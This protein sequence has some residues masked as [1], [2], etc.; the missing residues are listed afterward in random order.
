MQSEEKVA[1]PSNGSPIVTF[2]DCPDREEHFKWDIN[3]RD[4]GRYGGWDDTQE[5]LC[6]DA[7]H[8]SARILDYSEC[9]SQLKDNTVTHACHI[10]RGSQVAVKARWCEAAPCAKVCPR[11]FVR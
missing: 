2:A 3:P 8:L 6:P 10:G 5:N 9:A 1:K 4:G 11:G 7:S